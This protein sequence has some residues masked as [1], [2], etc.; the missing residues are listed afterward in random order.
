M[1]YLFAQDDAPDPALVEMLI[2]VGFSRQ[3]ATDT[4]Q[5]YGPRV[6][7]AVTF[8][9]SRLKSGY[10][11]ANP[12]GLIF[13]YLRNEGKYVLPA[14]IATEPR[15]ID[16]VNVA[17]QVAQ[18]EEERTLQQVESQLED[19]DQKSPFDQ[20]Q[21][22]KASLSILLSAYLS[23]SELDRL[24][25]TC[26]SGALKAL[27]VQRAAIAARA[28]K[29]LDQYVADLKKQLGFAGET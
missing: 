26:E 13:D 4:A 17:R 20:Y 2:G 15:A 21:E 29:T 5:Q 6:E 19:I 12:A 10:K 7:E 25:K 22:L 11:V 18:Q 24:K 1:T 27:E 16:I 3:R 8:L 9:R 28:S 14:E 23:K